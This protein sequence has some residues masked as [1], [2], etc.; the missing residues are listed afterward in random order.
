MD[1]SANKDVGG[2]AFAGED[3]ALSGQR[4]GVAFSGQR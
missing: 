3:D 2:G 1:V 4:A